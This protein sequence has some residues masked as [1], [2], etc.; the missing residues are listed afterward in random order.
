MDL[1]VQINRDNTDGNI[2]RRFLVPTLCLCKQQDADC[3]SQYVV[4]ITRVFVRLHILSLASYIRETNIYCKLQK[5]R[6]LFGR[7]PSMIA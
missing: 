2:G 5:A 1:M 4:S 7:V 3:N 6:H